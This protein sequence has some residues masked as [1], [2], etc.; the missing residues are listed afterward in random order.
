MVSSTPLMLVI[1][2]N[3]PA[4]SV[5]D[6]IQRIKEKPGAYSYG[7]SGNGTIIHLASEMM[8]KATKSDIVHIPY[9]GSAPLVTAIIT[10]D[11][12]YAFSSM[13]PAISQVKAGKLRALAVTTPSRVDILP[14]VPTI[15]EAGVSVAELTLYSGIMGPANMPAEIVTRLNEA[16][17]QAVKSEKI[18][19][20]FRNLGAAPL[21]M[22]PEEI[23][24]LLQAEI[25]RYAAVVKET[26]TRI[27]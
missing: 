14:D 10:G 5:K 20:N 13:P 15:K 19:Q 7:S 9:K 12:E 2:S 27:D 26:G 6:L 24:K 17:G 16:F 22:S 4:M 18:T 3:S 25:P 21:R 1:N 8:N 23:N 11:I